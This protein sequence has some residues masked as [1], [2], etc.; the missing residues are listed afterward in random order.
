MAS[1]T[2]TDPVL[3]AERAHLLRAR[4][5]LGR[6]RERAERIA[7]YGV[8][9]LASYALGAVRARRLRALADDPSAVVTVA[10]PRA[11]YVARENSQTCGLRSANVAARIAP[12][13][14]SRAFTPYKRQT[15][16]MARSRSPA[17]FSTARR[18]RRNSEDSPITTRLSCFC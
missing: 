10:L 1:P 6:M 8:D 3:L 9:E 13:S 14:A 12:G 2:A 17:A 7:D 4:E 5:Q 11:V 15:L 16:R 18:K